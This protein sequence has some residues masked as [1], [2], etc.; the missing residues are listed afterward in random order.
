M[1]KKQS[2]LQW[3]VAEILATYPETAGAFVQRRMACLGCA[4]APFETL[5]DALC[6][7]R[8]ESKGFVRDLQRR[9]D[10]KGETR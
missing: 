9:I 4:M 8:V 1:K 7:Y 2:F 5:R 6:A 10:N 3:T